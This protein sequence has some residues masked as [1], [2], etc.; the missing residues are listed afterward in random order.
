MTGQKNKIFSQVLYCKS[1]LF[2]LNGLF[3]NSGQVGKLLQV[4]LLKV[5]KQEAALIS[6]FCTHLEILDCMVLFLQYV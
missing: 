5:Y 1:V 6:T 4:M 3:A 2:A